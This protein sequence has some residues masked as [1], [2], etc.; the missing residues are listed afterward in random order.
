MKK[1]KLIFII[2]FIFISSL[3]TQEM[4]LL[5]GPTGIGGLKMM[6]DYKAVNIHFVNAPNN[7]LS[8][9]VKG[10]ADIAA[11]PANMAAIIF[12]RQLDYKVIAI[13]SETQLF[14]VSANEKIQTINDIKNKTVYCGTKLAAP[15]L[16]L[17][18]LISKENLPKVNINYSLSN[19]D[20]AKAVASKNADIAILPEPFVSSAMLENKDVHI[21]V[22]MSKYIENYPV[23]VLIAKN[24]FINHNRVLVNEVLREYEKSTYHIL[25]N[26]NEVE[27]LIKDSSM[28]INAKAAVYGMNRMG[29][30]FYSGEKMKFALNSYY[31]FLYNFDKKLIGNRIPSNDFYYIER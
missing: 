23:A 15:D 7:M 29:L 2:L 4:Y 6:K 14:I 20:L 30:T 1:I 22:E 25:N 13:I 31:N 9:I 5:N 21:V 28:I 17:Q 18:Y 3:Y 26:K 8:L 11:I 10:E 12:N 19:P 16:M 24:T 27:T